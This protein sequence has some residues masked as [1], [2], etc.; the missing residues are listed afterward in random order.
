MDKRW[1]CTL[2]VR[3]S[4]FL[5]ESGPA[6]HPRGKKTKTKTKKHDN[7]KRELRDTSENLNKVTSMYSSSEHYILH[8]S[9][10]S[11][12][13]NLN[14]VT[15]MYSSPEHYILHLSSVSA[16]EV[17]DGTRKAIG[18]RQQLSSQR[19]LKINQTAHSLILNI[20]ASFLKAK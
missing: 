11:A 2:S 16:V 12:V 10:V 1:Y 7:K 13:E 19:L 8:L 3:C 20:K 15:S 5:L 4:V 9:S 6:P 14:K 17:L 18:L